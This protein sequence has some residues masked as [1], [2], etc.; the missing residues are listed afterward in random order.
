MLEAEMQ[1][2]SMEFAKDV[3]YHRVVVYKCLADQLVKNQAVLTSYET[4]RDTYKDISLDISVLKESESR[5][6]FQT[7]PTIFGT[8]LDHFSAHD[9]YSQNHYLQQIDISNYLPELLDHAGITFL[10]P[11][12]L[13][14]NIISE[15]S[16]HGPTFYIGEKGIKTSLHYDRSCDVV[17]NPE[18]A[19]ND[20]GKNNLF[21]QLSGKRKFILFPSHYH[22]DLYPSIGSTT[23]HV[24]ESTTFLHSIPYDVDES[25][26]HEYLLQ[27]QYPKLANAWPARLEIVL[28]AGDGLLIPARWWHYTEILEAGS[29]LNWWFAMEENIEAKINQRLLEQTD[30]KNEPP[31]K[32]D[33]NCIIS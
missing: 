21:L 1:S 11:N 20:P 17:N 23:P 14:N 28:E 32:T 3:G 4:L 9:S 8:F 15:S 24:S 25:A 22:T 30:A 29:A 18:I 19:E 27:S 26:Q 12:M 33:K 7:E 5:P 31:R 6:P 2:F 10:A 13:S 16:C